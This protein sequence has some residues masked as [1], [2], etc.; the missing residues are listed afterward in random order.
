MKT[1]YHGRCLTAQEEAL[2]LVAYPDGT[3]L[4]IGAGHNDAGLKP[5]TTITIPQALALLGDDEA[6]REAAISKA[7]AVPVNQAQF[8]A[9][10]DA[11]F[12]KGTVIHPVIDLINKGDIDEAMALLLTF[13]RN[14]AGTFLL[15][16]ARRRQREAHLFMTG[17]YGDLSTV[18]VRVGPAGTPFIIEPMPS[19]T[20]FGAA[21]S[22][23]RIW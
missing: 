4:S 15:G 12:N 23:Q 22:E 10:T 3:H 20:T 8:D 6:S 17:D 11:W 5:G 13:N 14:K 1:S 9:L 7:L 16:L 2:A 18:K 21:S 19:E